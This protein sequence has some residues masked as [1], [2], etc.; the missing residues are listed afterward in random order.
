MGAQLEMALATKP[1]QT[2]DVSKP[3]PSL[4]RLRGLCHAPVASTILSLAE[5]VSGQHSAGTTEIAHDSLVCWVQLSLDLA[6]NDNDLPEASRFLIIQLSRVR[7]G[8]ASLGRYCRSLM[9]A[10]LDASPDDGNPGDLTLDLLRACLV[11]QSSS[12]QATFERLKHQIAKGPFDVFHVLAMAQREW[13]APMLALLTLRV[14]PVVLGEACVLTPSGAFVSGSN[15]DCSAG[16]LLVGSVQSQLLRSLHCFL[17]C[18][19]AQARSCPSE[20]LPSLRSGTDVVRTAGADFGDGV[21]GSD[22]ARGLYELYGTFLL[23]F[24]DVVPNCCPEDVSDGV[25]LAAPLVSAALLLRSLRKLANVIESDDP[26]LGL[27]R[28]QQL[29]KVASR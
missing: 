28:L 5:V 25:P 1:P 26:L 17:A 14:L 2:G 9:M 15:L 16:S 10:V 19:V 12:N 29:E 24:L 20:A 22:A 21:H 23:A 18:V 8:T 13:P 4:G 7:A 6:G 11:A 27:G 3:T